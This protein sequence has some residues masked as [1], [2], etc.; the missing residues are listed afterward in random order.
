V[1]W[2]LR[3]ITVNLA[4]TS[5][6]KNGSGLD[7]AIA[8]GILVAS[9]ELKPEHVEG[10]GFL[11][12]LGLDGKLRRV[13]G[14]V[15]MVDAIQSPALVVPTGTA[16][17]AALLGRHVVRSAPT[18]RDVIDAL[19]G[20]EPWPDDPPQPDHDHAEVPVPDLADVRGQRMGRWALEIAA[21]GGHHLLLIGPPGSGKTMLARR[22]PGLLPLLGPADALETTKVHS[23]AGLALPPNGLIERPPFRAPHHN[24]SLVSL[25]GGGTSFMRPGEISLSHPGASPCHTVA[26][27]SIEEAT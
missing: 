26:R 14:I 25:I 11:G 15:P 12:E 13:P 6:R 7:L 22:L 24:A 27:C 20:E 23:A 1:K 16:R 9:G 3:R 10:I 2:P 4:P 21:A 19:R 18:L 5:E 17:E 8:I